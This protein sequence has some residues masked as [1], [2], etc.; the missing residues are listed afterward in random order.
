MSCTYS[1][2]ESDSKLTC[3]VRT[4][5]KK[6]AGSIGYGSG[7]PTVVGGMAPVGA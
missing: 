3:P 6:P 1:P 2:I 4:L 7:S 5:V